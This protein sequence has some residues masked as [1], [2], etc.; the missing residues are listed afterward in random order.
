MDKEADN[1]LQGNKVGLQEKPRNQV[2]GERNNT[3][4]HPGTKENRRDGKTLGQLWDSTK[5]FYRERSKRGKPE[6][7]TGFKWIDEFTD[8]LHEG[9]VWCVSGRPAS[10]KTSLAINIATHI[11]DE[12]KSV[13]FISLE[14]TGEQ[15]VSRMFCEMAGFDHGRLRIGDFGED[16]GLKDKTFTNFINSVDFEIMEKGYRI[17][18]II[19]ILKSEYSGNKPDLIVLDFVQLIDKEGQDDRLALDE[20]MRKITELA[21][22][23]NLAIIIISQLR[24]LPSGAD[25]NREPDMQ[26]NRG[27]GMIEQLASVCLIIYKIIEKQMGKTTEKIM[28][29]IAKNRHGPTGEREVGF[30]GNQFKFVEINQREDSLYAEK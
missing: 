30:I 18:D 28:I 22:L 21:K 6:L 11:A 13:L 27:S 15:L 2:P 9:E 14:M 23:H 26:D 17:S 20:F 24:R 8:G 12:N 4:P 10:G 29:K 1:L 5:D 7:S 3:Y 16:F 25:I 19:N